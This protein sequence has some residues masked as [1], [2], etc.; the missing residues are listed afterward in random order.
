MRYIAGR[1]S[2]TAGD[3]TP[4]TMALAAEIRVSPA[5]ASEHLSVLRA[6]R[7][8]VAHVTAVG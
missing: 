8:V 1:K 4:G 7:L 6:A 3:Q 2:P 5:T